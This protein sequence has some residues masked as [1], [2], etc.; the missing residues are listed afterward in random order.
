MLLYGKFAINRNVKLIGRLSRETGVH[1]GKK[2]KKE[3]FFLSWL[4]SQ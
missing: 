3:C 2:K 1:L 4:R